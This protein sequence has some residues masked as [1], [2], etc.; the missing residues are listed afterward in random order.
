MK[1]LCGRFKPQSFSEAV[2]QPILV[3]MY[4]SASAPSEPG[5]DSEAEPAPE[6]KI[7]EVD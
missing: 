1:Y 3:K 2:I 5:A 6:P 4:G 7:E